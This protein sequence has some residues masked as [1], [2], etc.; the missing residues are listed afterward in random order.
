MP[1]QNPLVLN[2]LTRT[3]GATRTGV[4]YA[5][6]I[7]P[8]GGVVVVPGSTTPPTTNFGKTPIP[9]G[10]GSMFK[11]IPTPSPTYTPWPTG[12]P[13]ITQGV[14]RTQSSPQP[15]VN[16]S[17]TSSVSVGPGAPRGNTTGFTAPPAKLK[18]SQNPA[19]EPKVQQGMQLPIN[20]KF[21]LPPHKWSLPTTPYTVE[22]A[23]SPIKMNGKTVQ[24]LS[25]PPNVNTD[26][27]TMKA[28]VG[29]NA[30]DV[31]SP[32]IEA[33][34]TT[35]GF[36]GM[37]RARLWFYNTHKV[38]DGYT[39]EE[40]KENF[41]TTGTGALNRG[42]S[43][44]P[45]EAKNEQDRKTLIE[46]EAIDRNY[47]FQFLWNPEFISISVNVNMEVTPSASD[48]FR[49]VAGF[50]PGMEYI[51][52]DIM[53]DRTND[54]ACIQSMRGTKWN[55]TTY[56][57]LAK[58][59]YSPHA[60]PLQNATDVGLGGQLEELAKLGTLH[61]IEYLFKSI[62]GASLGGKEWKNI[63]GRKTADIGFLQPTL[64]AIQLGPSRDNL[65]YVGWTNSL[66][67][68][69]VAFTQTMIPIRTQVKMSINCFAGQMIE[70][71]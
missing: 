3:P 50:F 65:S 28:G 37:R 7:N 23:S 62:N 60:F 6:T 51:N 56:A 52:L 13:S 53:I 38:V 29:E 39:P 57:Q 64:L 49:S 18:T 61:D 30:K 69:H 45:E 47:G 58:K 67:V 12:R 68:N 48:R 26:G 11:P 59:Y 22:N 21:N 4:P 46:Q 1:D 15:Q 36:H 40:G 2:P 31:T 35:G 54:F 27:M 42:V 44:N 34:T 43:R 33:F 41:T 17:L 70:G 55:E 63:L 5:T 32:E 14:P 20:F 24:S 8:A 25:I 19:N 10:G 16:T 71:L 66:S 9:F